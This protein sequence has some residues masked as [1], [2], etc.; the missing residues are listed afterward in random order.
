[1][2]NNAAFSSTE[3]QQRQK[4]TGEQWRAEAMRRFGDDVLN[5]RF[6]C[7]SC[8]AE[9][10]AAQWS[11]AG[12]PSTA[13]AFSCVGRWKDGFGCKYAGGGPL[14]LNPITVVH[15][16]GTEA[17][18]FAFADVDGVDVAPADDDD[19]DDDADE[20]EDEE[21]EEYEDAPNEHEA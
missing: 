10:R 15:D 4:M 1:M 7:P 13:V 8:G 21:D 11:A 16:D 17:D 6:V 9:I 3:Q 5:W 12:A 18:Y 19:D 14:K 2:S 20:D